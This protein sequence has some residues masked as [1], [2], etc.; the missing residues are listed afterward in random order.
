MEYMNNRRE[1]ILDTYVYGIW[2]HVHN[3]NWWLFISR[4]IHS[5]K[6]F[7]RTCVEETTFWWR[8]FAYRVSKNNLPL[9]S[10]WL[11]VQSTRRKF[12]SPI[13]MLFSPLK[14]FITSQ[15][16]SVFCL[17]ELGDPCT[18]VNVKASEALID[19]ID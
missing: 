7:L 3:N 14:E 1:T 11:W 2:L 5:Y 6:I 13:I 8:K 10:A 19:K 18:T 4:I 12:Q 9:L 17:L 16:F 15:S